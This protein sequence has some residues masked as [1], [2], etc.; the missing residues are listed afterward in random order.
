MSEDDW[1]DPDLR[2][3]GMFVSGTPLRE[4][5]PEGERLNDWTFLLWFHAGT[6]PID[7]V[8]PV[9]EW[10]EHGEVVLS[11]DPDYE[12]G[13]PVRAGETLTLDARSVLVLRSTEFGEPE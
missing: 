12:V 8:L 6:E 11:T 4:P 7:V 10:V 3:L 13:K 9:T 2:T 5:G 1:F